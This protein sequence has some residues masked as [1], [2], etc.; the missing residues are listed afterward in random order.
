MSA[1]ETLPLLRELA[2]FDGLDERHLEALAQRCR[3]VEFPTKA[4]IFEEFERAKDVYFVVNGQISIA[5][6][7][8]S[9][10]RQITMV[11][12]GELLGWSPLIGRS[13]LFDTA[14]TATNVK[15]LAF[16]GE[17]LLD[18]C[19][20]NTDFGFE[21]VRRVASVL[22]DRLAATRIQLLELSGVHFPVVPLES[23]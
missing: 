3:V 8:A 9:G 19:R 23:D 22:G 21:F 1:S 2:F 12:K 6:C 10:C 16:D 17:E 13:R 4:T 11:G 15:A 20:S 18:Y 14:R 7:D 5:I